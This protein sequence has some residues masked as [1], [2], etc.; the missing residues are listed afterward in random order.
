MFYSLQ[1]SIESAR[2]ANARQLKVFAISPFRYFPNCVTCHQP[3]LP[4][5]GGAGGGVIGYER[6]SEGW[7]IGFE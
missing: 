2:V 7:V 3:P 4:P 1:T 6:W 5:G